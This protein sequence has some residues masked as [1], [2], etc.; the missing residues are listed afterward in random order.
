LHSVSGYRYCDFL[1][2]QGKY[3]EVIY[4]ASRTLP[5]AERRNRLLDI[6]LDNVSL[7]RAH[8]PNSAESALHLDRAV[9]CLRPSYSFM[10]P[11]G[12]L[13]R[14]TTRDL[15]EVFRIATRS[16]MRLY[17]TDYHLVS[18]LIAERAGDIEK[19]YKHIKAA[20]ALVNETGYGR[21]TSD[22]RRLS[23]NLNV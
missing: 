9:D 4:R 18:A 1:I 20:E 17:L 3:E 7:G 2:G 11:I 19:A 12:L 6:G 8:R 5:M 16:G 14:G 15:D 10:L 21:R 23:A 22:L 13:A